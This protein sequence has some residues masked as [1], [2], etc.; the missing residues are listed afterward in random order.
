MKAIL[1]STERFPEWV[2]E[3][4]KNS[5]HWRN[6]K[7]L[8]FMEVSDKFYKDYVRITEEFEK[9]QNELNEIHENRKVL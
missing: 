6:A 4:D 8:D 3:T 2:F 5:Y 9:L 7:P 1:Y